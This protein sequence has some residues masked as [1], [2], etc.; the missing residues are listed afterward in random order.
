M[1]TASCC[2]GV[3]D[4][5]Y[6]AQLEIAPQK[7]QNHFEKGIKKSAQFR[8]DLDI[9]WLFLFAQLHKIFVKQ[10]NSFNPFQV[11]ENSKMFIWRVDGIA[12]KTKAHKY[13]FAF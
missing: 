8:L 4:N 6:S 13:C 1:E 2:P 12:I 9:V 11:I 3:R 7:K 5:R 10:R